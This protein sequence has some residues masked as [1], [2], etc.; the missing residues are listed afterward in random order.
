M[1][2]KQIITILF[3]L[4][5]TNACN[6]TERGAATHPQMQYSANLIS[7]NKSTHNKIWTH[8]NIQSHTDNQTFPPFITLANG[9]FSSPIYREYPFRV[10]VD[11]QT[12]NGQVCE[13]ESQDCEVYIDK[14]DPEE[15]EIHIISSE[16]EDET[17]YY[18]I[19]KKILS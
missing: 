5:A 17:C 3:L 9:Q 16:R 4:Q 19:H 11:I 12:K 14:A 10:T 15:T 18:S 13:C 1:Y 6:A 2:F 7:T 8:V